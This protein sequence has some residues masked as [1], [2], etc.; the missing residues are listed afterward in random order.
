MCTAIHPASPD[1]STDHTCCRTA[2]FATRWV[3]PSVAVITAEGEL[4][5]ANSQ[6]FADYTLRQAARSA[7]VVVDLAGV[8]F[9]GTAG[10]SALHAVNIRCVAQIVRWTLVPS[11][12]V[13][14]L[15]AICDP[16]ATLP[17]CQST[18]AA[19]SQLA[20]QPRLLE[21]VPEPS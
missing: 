2:H 3:Q 7:H 5:A 9:F 14:R 4:D 17:V 12:A 1:L 15:L 10:F 11:P 21:L 20:A 13:R 6:D 18:D 19:L 16:L 8:E